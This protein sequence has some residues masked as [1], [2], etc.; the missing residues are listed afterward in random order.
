M[1]DGRY[2]L[3]SSWTI[4]RSI[5]DSIFHMYTTAMEDESCSATQESDVQLILYSMRVE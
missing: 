4:S 1:W 3:D 2:E 5:G